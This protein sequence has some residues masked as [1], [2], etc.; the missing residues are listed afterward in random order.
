MVFEAAPDDAV[1]FA[2][3]SRDVSAASAVMQ[4]N[5][6][7][8]RKYVALVHSA[9]LVTGISIGA[10]FYNNAAVGRVMLARIAELP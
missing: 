6:G 10:W 2:S 1:A 5:D 7:H 9:V 4:A 8:D 3:L